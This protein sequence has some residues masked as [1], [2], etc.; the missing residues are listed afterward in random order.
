MR[1]NHFSRGSCALPMAI[2]IGMLHADLR[3][4]YAGVPDDVFNRSVGATTR[5]VAIGSPAVPPVFCGAVLNADDGCLGLTR[6]RPVSVRM[7]QALAKGGC[8]SPTFRAL[9][10]AIESSRAFVYILE[11][12]YLPP[13][14][15][16][17]VPLDVGG[18]GPDRYFRVV[19]KAGLDDRYTIS[20]IGHELQHVLELLREAGNVDR[21]KAETWQIAPHQYETQRAVEVE[22]QVTVEL[23][24]ACRRASDGVHQSTENSTHAVPRA[25]SELRWASR[26]KG[27]E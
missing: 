4:A 3:R 22:R 25:H 9:V 27:S 15:N 6:V 18:A 13:H 17:C 8:Q 24:R 19:I 23:R 12:P 2:V 16:G 11:V 14:M 20:V 10:N 26:R 1:N 7:V 5:R 21:Q